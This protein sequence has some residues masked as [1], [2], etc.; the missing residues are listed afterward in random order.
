MDAAETSALVSDM[1][2]VGIGAGE[3]NPRPL[4]NNLHKVVQPLLQVCWGRDALQDRSS[5]ALHSGFRRR[6]EADVSLCGS[7]STTAVR[8]ASLTCKC[9]CII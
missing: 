7:R 6:Q 8:S 9:T 5:D 2:P 1:L 4:Q 3:R